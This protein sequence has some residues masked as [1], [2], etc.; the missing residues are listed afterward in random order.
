MTP[1]LGVALALGLALG[2]LSACSPPRIPVAAPP[3]PDATLQ[4]VHV[5]T[6]Q[7]EGQLDGFFGSEREGDRRFGRVTVSI[8]P[9][10]VA[11]EIEWPRG[12]PDSNKH[13]TVADI[14]EFSSERAM[15][16]DIRARRETV[17]FVHG[18]NNNVAEAVFQTA[19]I[20]EDFGITSPTV[21]FAWPSAADLRGYLYDRD[22]VLFARRD[23]RMSLRNLSRS[24]GE[25]LIIAHSMG[26]LLVMEALRDLAQRG[27]RATLARVSGL[28]L[29]SP[30]ID[31]DV[32]RRQVDEIQEAV[33]LPNPF[34]VFVAQ[35]DQALRI[36]SLFTG[37]RNRLGTLTSAEDVAGLPVT[38]IDLTAFGETRSLNHQI[39]LESP[40]AIA[41]LRR[42]RDG[43]ETALPLLTPFIV[44]DNGRARDLAGRGR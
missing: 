38:L 37:G 35:Q 1:R 29:I 20:R 8:P 19:Q 44:S 15:H 2:L 31:P 25:V 17:M 14:K 24:E 43:D 28:I 21:A 41:L 18:F 30:D 22:S 16:A 40:S 5:I 23:F 11:G 6:T 3:N 42:L 7:P 13:F 26:A 32:F 27:D 39:I 36:S 10:H 12:V 9:K 34:V 33:P 4:D